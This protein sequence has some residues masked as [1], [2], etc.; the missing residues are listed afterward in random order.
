MTNPSPVTALTPMP[1]AKIS[2]PLDRI[3]YPILILLLLLSATPCRAAEDQTLEL[4]SPITPPPTWVIQKS[5]KVFHLGRYANFEGWAAFKDGEFQAIYVPDTR[6]FSLNG[7]LFAPNGDDVTREQIQNLITTN[8]EAADLFNKNKNS[9]P[10]VD[11]SVK[12]NP[13]KNNPVKTPPAETANTAAT[14]PGERLIHQLKTSPGVTFGGKNEV[15]ILYVLVSPSSPAC[16]TFWKNIRDY[17]KNGTVRI[18]LIPAGLKD[19][20]DEHMSAKLLQAKDPLTAWDEWVVDSK[21]DRLSG[22]ADPEL[23]AEVQYNA[24]IIDKW[25]FPAAPYTVYRDKSGKVKVVQGVP[26]DTKALIDDAAPETAGGSK[27]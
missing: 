19:S 24:S 16:Q 25:R 15:P 23:V 18:H 20:R 5:G 22:I 27:P 10:G 9:V 12:N 2:S 17:V 13:V 11:A 1:N 26:T 6:N 3:F 8:K 4:D 21:D 14:S 7:H